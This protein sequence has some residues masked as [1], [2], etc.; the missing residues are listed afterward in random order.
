MQSYRTLLKPLLNAVPNH[1]SQC[2]HRYPRS[3]RQ[4]ILLDSKIA[5]SGKIDGQWVTHQWL[6]SGAALFR[7]NDNQVIEGQKAATR[8]K[9]R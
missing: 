5:C 4:V 9:C 6:K 7:I 1:A 3:G 8:T 2:R